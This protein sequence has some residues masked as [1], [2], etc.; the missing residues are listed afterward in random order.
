MSY[1]ITLIPGD[2]IGPE[3]TEATREVLAATGVAIEWEL[4]E[5][6]AA[7]AEQHGHPCPDDVIA[8]V[9][10]NRIALKGPIG[11]PIGRGFRSVNV[12][13]RKALDLYACLRPVKN[14]EGIASRF[15]G[16]DLVIVR[17]NTEGLY[18]GLEHMVVPGVAESLK[19]VS[20]RAST[21]IAEF[22][23]RYARA[24]NRRRV[25][26][27]H[28]ANI[29]KLSDGLFLDSVRKVSR[30]YAEVDTSEV[31]VDA[32]AMQLVRFPERFDVL[33]MDNL[34]GDILSDLCA[35]LVGGLGVVP[36][37][38]IGD[39]CAVFEAVHGSAPDIAGKGVANPTA[40]I[41]SAALMLQYLGERE[42]S[43][44]VEQAIR[45]VYRDTTVRT[46]DLG[47]N[48]TTVEFTRAVV[49]AL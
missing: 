36:G 1:V 32:C 39:E 41:L 20:E 31:I 44:R 17:E 35:G 23:F 26:V 3:V 21:R 10:R 43:A 27:V 15:S 45:K 6:G 48:A 5:A 37:A 42:A 25:S 14:I 12:T 18:S 40:L 7:A 8:S 28:K 4:R 16:V 24:N 9:Q 49:Q 2:G 46:G 22:A 33:V 38:N 34:Y 47:G 30:R 19:I 29:M 11:T 13:L